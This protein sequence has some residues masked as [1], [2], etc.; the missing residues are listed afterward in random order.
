M[1]TLLPPL[2]CLLLTGCG[3]ASL[4][5]TVAPGTY[6]TSWKADYDALGNAAPEQ[7]P[8]RDD[9]GL[10]GRDLCQKMLDEHDLA[11]GVPMS[12]LASFFG[13][14]YA[15]INDAGPSRE[16]CAVVRFAPEAGSERREAGWHLVIRFDR[17]QLA[18]RFELSN[19]PVGPGARNPT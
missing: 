14:H 17:N 15:R 3:G 18:T 1:K 7:A 10:A 5:P 2:L 8:R 4:T 19:A 13:P 9:A 6:L 12:L 16:G 11:P